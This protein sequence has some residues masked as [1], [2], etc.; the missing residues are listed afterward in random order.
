MRRDALICIAAIAVAA[1]ALAADF[2]KPY[3]RQCTERENVFAF[4]KKP[5]VN[6]VAKDKYEITF[7]VKGYCDVTVGLIDAK[8]TVLR[9]LAAG[10]LGKNAPAPFQK[11]SLKQKIYWNGQDDLGVYVKEPARLMIRVRLGLKPEYDKR[12]GVTN[13]KSIP[14]RLAWGIACDESGVYVGAGN[15]YTRGDRIRKFDHDG[16]YVCTVSPPPANLP[17]EKLKGMGFVEYEA[18]RK[19]L[20]SPDFLSVSDEHN[21]LPRALSLVKCCQ[22]TIVGSRLYYCTRAAPEGRGPSLLHYINTDG[23]TELK[24]A[25]GRPFLKYSTA[26]APFS[27]GA[28]DWAF[29]AASWDGKWLYLTG[30]NFRGS[31]VDALFRCSLENDTPGGILVGEVGKSGSDNAHFQRPQGLDCDGQGRVYVCDFGNNRIQVFAPDGKHAK[32]ISFDRPVEIKVHRKTGAL[33]VRHKTRVQGKTVH[34]ISKLTSYDNPAVELYLDCPGGLMALDSWAAKP[35]VWL[36]GDGNME[37]DDGVGGTNVR[38]WEEAGKEFRKFADFQEEVTKEAEAN[39]RGP[40]SGLNRGGQ[41]KIVCDP[42]RERAYFNSLFFDLKTGAILFETPL[43]GTDD[44]AFDKSG[45]MHCHFNPSYQPGVG[46]VDPNQTVTRPWTRDWGEWTRPWPRTVFKECP[47]DYGVEGKGGWTGIVQTKDQLGA[48]YFQDGVGVNMQGDVAVQSNIYYAP[49]RDDDAVQFAMAG[50]EGF[51]RKGEYQGSGDGVNYAN[52]L[53]DIK[54]RQKRG[55]EVYWI[56]PKPGIPLIGATIWTY[57]KN[58]EVRDE[59]AVT[60]GGLIN[61]VQID[62]DGAVYFVSDKTRQ[63]DDKPFLAGQGG[64]FGAGKDAKVANPFTGAPGAKQPD[65]FTGTLIK[66]RK[67]AR[68]LSRNGPIPLEELPARPSDFM[69]RR[70]GTWKVWIEGAEWL[71]A[72][73]SPIV[74]GSCSCPTMRIHTDWYKRTFVPEQYRHSIGVVDTA[75]NLILHF[76][77]YGNFDSGNGLTSKIPVGSDGIAFSDARMVSGTD[78]Y[79][80]FSDRGERVIVLKLNYH[81][82]ETVSIKTN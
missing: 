19:E 55:E 71:Y 73:A 43:K 76:G 68:M 38:I 46:R 75:G 5:S 3:D 56:R 13:P 39:H 18:G 17:P 21:F 4:T 78:N 31:P 51:V 60:A 12:L 59:C 1:S 11:D 79:L 48:K 49:K 34:R 16:N 65:P 77:Q 27:Q 32:T 70:D 29:L 20:Q 7:A 33:Y 67:K 37:G 35:R 62:E 15:K 58:G 14:G 74:N 9:H 42:T 50:N 23:S 80:C 69:T 45:Y 2:P 82:E 8:G 6:L 47:Y 40:W 63:I 54:Q 22:F 64:I 52:F 30:Q 44:A 72:G 26:G 24:G 81:A 41:G 28:P 57:N 53:A 10:V 36:F 25:A 66:V 61:G